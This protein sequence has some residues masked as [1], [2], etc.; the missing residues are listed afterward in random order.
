MTIETGI[1]LSREQLLAIE[2]GVKEIA[3]R[4]K[5]G[6]VD[7]YSP[8]PKQQQFHDL[9]LTKRERLLSAGNQNGKTYCGG[10][11]ASYHLTGRYPDWWLGRRWNRPTVGWVAGVTGESTRDN[12]QRILC[13]RISDGWGTGMLPHDAVDWKRDCSMA[14]GVADLFDT[15]LVKHVSGG[16]SQLQFKSYEKGREKWQG[17]TVDWIWN[18]EEPPED[19]YTEGLTRIT[20]TNGM[21]YITFT[22]LQGPTEVVNRFMSP[23]METEADRLGAKSRGHVNMTI[24]DAVHI[25]P[26]RRAEI[27]AGW[28]EHEREAREKG[29]PMLGS[30]RVFRATEESIRID[31]IPIMPYWRHIWGMD[32]GQDHPFAAVAMAWDVETDTI[33]VYHTIRMSDKTIVQQTAAMKAIKGGAMMPAAWPQ[34]GHVRKEWGGELKPIATIFRLNGIKTLAEHAKHLDGSNS[35]EAGLLQMDERM[36]SNR[37]K[38]FSTLPDWWEEYRVYHRKAGQLVKVKDD[39]MSATRTGVMQI[40]SAKAVLFDPVSGGALGR[41]SQIAEGTD[42]DVFTGH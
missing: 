8:Y 40:R 21:V 2:K 32:F 9:G 11:E 34:D 14:R 30:G 1:P 25:A 41:R 17:D 15:I 5:F 4:K 37:F 33:Y 16:H 35:T 18:D 13:G 39:L 12:P 42:F 28:P 29:I 24:D 27:V 3:R 38:V 19:V 23:K 31:P 20:A 26:E 6:R 7:F 22:P 36:K 10:A